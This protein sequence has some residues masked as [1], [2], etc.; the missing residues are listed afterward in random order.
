MKRYYTKHSLNNAKTLRANL[1]DTEHILWFHLRNRRL[2]NI[3]FRRQVPIGSYIVDFLCMDKKLIIELDGSQH[4]NNTEYD[5]ERTRYLNSIGYKVI[6]V[7]NNDISNRIEQVLEYI[8][9]EYNK[10]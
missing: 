3:K 8:L 7:Y 1:T 9:L 5:S 6:R 4:M 2:D 10:I